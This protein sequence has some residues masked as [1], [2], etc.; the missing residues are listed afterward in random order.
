MLSE[1]KIDSRKFVEFLRKKNS[2]GNMRSIHLNSLPTQRGYTKLA[3]D[4]LGYVGEDLPQNFLEKLFNDKTFFLTIKIKDFSRLMDEHKRLVEERDRASEKN[5]TERVVSIE[6]EIKVVLTEIK[7]FKRVLKSLSTLYSRTREEEQETGVKTFAFGY[8][9]LVKRSNANPDK[10]IKAPLLIF[11]LDIEQSTERARTW[12]IT[13]SQDHPVIVNN[14]LLSHIENDIGINIDNLG[15]LLPEDELIQKEDIVNLL[16]ELV[17]SVNPEAIGILSKQISFEELDGLDNRKAIERE[18][19]ENNGLIWLNNGVF[20]GYRISKESVLADLRALEKLKEKGENRLGEKERL[21]PLSPI[22]TDPSQQGIINSLQERD[23]ILIQGPPGTGKSQSLTAI[24]SNALSNRKRC[25]VVCEKKTALDVISE[26]LE[27]QG[28]GDLVTTITN[29]MSDRG[30]VVGDIRELFE[31]NHSFSILPEENFKRKEKDILKLIEKINQQ[32]KNIENSGFRSKTWTALVGD[33]LKAKKNIKNNPLVESL[34]RDD[35]NF[36]VEEYRQIQE[37]IKEIYRYY[38]EIVK[39]EA[40][41]LIRK[42]QYINLPLLESRRKIT[43]VIDTK[44]K[45]VI[46]LRSD[47]RKFFREYEERN[48]KYFTNGY[49]KLEKK[50]QELL[51]GFKKASR[52]YEDDLEM[53]YEESNEAL[54]V[55]IGEIKATLSKGKTSYGDQFMKNSLFNKGAI[56]IVSLLPGKYQDIKNIRKQ[57]KLLLKELRVSIEENEVLKFKFP[58][59]WEFDRM[60]NLEELEGLLQKLRKYQKTFKAESPSQVKKYL[61]SITLGEF[62]RHPYVKLPSEVEKLKDDYK[63]MVDYI[64]S[65]PL[66]DVP[67]IKKEYKLKELIRVVDETLL[68]VRDLS[69]SV[70]IRVSQIL[71]EVSLKDKSLNR[72]VK[73]PDLYLEILEKELDFRKQLDEFLIKHNLSTELTLREL[74]KEL[75]SLELFCLNAQREVG[76]NWKNFYDFIKLLEDKDTHDKAKKIAKFLYYE[77]KTSRWTEYFTHWYFSILLEIMYGD[78]L[79][80]DSKTDNLLDDLKKAMKENQDQQKEQILAIWAKEKDLRKQKFERGKYGHRNVK[81]LYNLRGSRGQR[82]NSL[83]NIVQREFKLFTSVK[84]VVLTNPITCSSIFPL[85]ENLFDIII[86][87]EASQLRIEDTYPA[88]YRGRI[89]IVSGDKHQMPPSYYF[90]SKYDFAEYEEIGDLEIDKDFASHEEEEELN[91]LI[92][93]YKDIFSNLVEAESLLSFAELLGFKETHLD[94]HYRSRHPD[95]IEFSNAAFYGNNLLPLPQKIEDRPIEL[96]RVDG[97]YEDNENVDEIKHVFK[98]LKTIE[99]KEDG[100]YPSIGIATFNQKQ[101]ARFYEEVSLS[102]DK[103]FKKRFDEMQQSGLFV[104]NLENIQGEERDIIILS[105]TFGINRENKFIQ[106][107]GPINRDQGYRLLN[108]LVTRAKEKIHVCT[109]IPERYIS[110]FLDDIN[111]NGNRRKGIFYAYLAYAQAV[112]DEDLERKEQILGYLRQNCEEKSHHKGSGLM[113]ETESVFE[114]EVISRLEDLINADRI[115]PQYG[116]GGFRIDFVVKDL[117]GKPTLAIECD[118]AK[119]HSS[120]E[121]Y[122]WDICRQQLLEEH[123]FIF[124]RIW[125]TDWFTNEKRELE[126]LVAFIQENEN[127]NNKPKSSQIKRGEEEKLEGSREEVKNTLF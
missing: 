68:R 57:L 124:H 83:R 95:L 69:N 127:P 72:K 78:L 43:S 86:F 109:S 60:K 26:N 27:E 61:Q 92:E 79:L 89:K 25:L 21:S 113:A 114:E 22:E 66:F 9:I 36:D 71:Q 16:K 48:R 39:V 120:P 11:Y 20:G 37:E 65:N 116:A 97:L 76:D 107:F 33:F 10:I 67:K 117:A 96:H 101:Q 73:T 32:H 54:E 123:G 105:T 51:E 121:A 106:N 99:K 24:I 111:I 93:D 42:E 80:P 102:E 44:Q 55:R 13:R 47:L 104:K 70:D 41:K 110:T 82:R 35:Y 14:L 40:L 122:C 91:N 103:E 94:T 77:S 112:S 74:D 52:E 45:L 17:Q 108:V 53:Y 87:D 34:D 50:L 38:L 100:S 56:S 23:K 88:L 30:K 1:F 28:L 126:E 125:S 2:L 98:L 49:K 59:D 8:P 75:E 19:K 15:E 6:K 12:K 63:K 31:V 4:K 81:S 58:G 46:G 3:L 84:P 62:K 90:A 118:G 5:D 7:K 29:P 119:Y 64:S 85:E 115:L 18:C